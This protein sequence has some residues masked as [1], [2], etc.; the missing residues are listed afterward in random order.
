MNPVYTTDSLSAAGKLCEAIP[1][2]AHE[3][4][5]LAAM[6]AEAFINGMTARDMLDAGTAQQQ[7]RT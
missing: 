4:A 1:N 2:A 3:R 7:T 5:V 6:M